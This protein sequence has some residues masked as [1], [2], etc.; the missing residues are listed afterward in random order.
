MATQPTSD[1]HIQVETQASWTPMVVIG[2]AQILMVFNISS[3]QVSIDGIVSS[4]NAPATAIGTAIVTY[5][6]VVAGFI[7]LG[8][9]L[10][11]IYGSR[12][13]FQVTIALFGV[14]MALMALSRG[15]VMMIA[16]QALAGVAAAAL[17]PTLVVLVADNYQGSQQEKALGWLGGAQAMGI[18]LAFLVAGAFSTWFGWRITFGLLVLLAG[19]IF[20]LSNKLSPVKGQ[21]GIVIDKFGVLLAASAV[22]LI[23][24]GA[25]NLVE[26][27]VLLAGPK[28]PFNI[29]DMSPAPIMIVCGIFLIQAFFDWSNRRQ[30]S[31]QRPLVALEVLDSPKERCA[32]YSMFIIGALGSAITFLVPLYIQIV[33]GRS[34]FQTAVAVIPFSLAS[35]LAAVLI[36]RL[37][38]RLS[39]R[40][41]ARYAFLVVTL[42]V[43]LLGAVIRNEWG[44]VMVVVGMFLTGLGEGALITLL[45][46]V[47]VSASPKEMAGDVGSLRGT[48]NN[49]AAG[50]G[51]AMAGALLVSVLG[52][53]VH[54]QLVH[55]PVIPN[56]L[57]MEMNLDSVPFISNGELRERLGRTVATPN[58]VAEAVRVNTEARLLALKISFF[59]LAGISLMAF[60]PAGG[61]P[62]KVRSDVPE[63]SDTRKKLR[64]IDE[65]GTPTTDDSSAVT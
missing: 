17:V 59:A 21:S 57:K 58:Q 44:N 2:M 10:G 40:R 46:N 41:I 27:G 20:Q 25:N 28:A 42:G 32:I 50:V 39:P 15:V 63:P 11:R 45:F 29:L 64:L 16:A 31:G 30:K 37:F 60:F 3:L 55:N 12:R 7:L 43:G 4:F 33:Q 23:S 51:T 54:R 22:F 5:S 8:A 62:G 1:V 6:L 19:V 47:L 14:A 61:L 56:A 13:V 48:T 18:V 53:S 65:E 38:D 35:F 52:T 26:W 9:K 24:I 49:L 34:G 36:V